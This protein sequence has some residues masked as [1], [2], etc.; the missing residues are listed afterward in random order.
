MATWKPIDG[1]FWPYRINEEAEIER[2]DPH[3]NKWVRITPFLMRD[4]KKGSY[5]R[6]FVN[7]KLSNGR[8]KNVYLKNLMIDVF[9]GGRKEGIVYGFKNGSIMDCSKNNLYPT[10]Q[11]EIAKRSGGGL[12]KSIEKIDRFGNV[13]DLYSSVTEAAEKNFISRKSVTNRCKNRVE[14]PFALTGFSFRYER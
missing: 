10:N 11:T 8:F 12:R 4:G 9:F 13:L 6:M 7:M 5:G 14:D 1:Y 3:Y 2:F